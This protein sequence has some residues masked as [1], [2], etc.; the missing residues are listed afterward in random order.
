MHRLPAFVGGKRR[1]LTSVPRI[2]F[3]DCGIR[4]AML[5]AFTPLAARQ[6]LGALSETYAFL[7]IMQHLPVPWT[8]HYWRTK[9]GAEV[10]FVLRAGDRCIAVE[11]KAGAQEPRVGR[12]GRSFIDAYAPE[13]FIL[14]HGA[15]T[16]ATGTKSQ[17]HVGSTKVVTCPLYELGGILD[18]AFS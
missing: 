17:P 9:G 11:V 12:S 18:A 8:A 2:H 3:Y 14:A 1:E 15:V 13:Q 7:E 5:S 16:S 10:D 6:D 4:N